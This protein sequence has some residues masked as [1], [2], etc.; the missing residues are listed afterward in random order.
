MLCTFLLNFHIHLKRCL[1]NRLGKKVIVGM[2]KNGTEFETF[3]KAI[4]EEI[5][6]YDG[7]DTVKVE[8]NVKVNGKSGQL[9]QLDV[10]WEFKIAGITHRVAVE[11]KQYAKTISVGKV[12]DFYGALE[13]IGNIHGIFVTTKGYQSGAIKYAAHKGISLK[14]VHEPTSDDIDAHQGIK[15]IHIKGNFM[16]IGNVLMNLSLDI[17]WVLEHT[18]MKEGDQFSF[19]ALNNEIKV[20]DS[21]FNLLGTIHD[22]ENK[23]PREPENT[24]ALTNKYEF[25]DGFIHVPNSKYPLLKLKALHFK[26]DTYSFSTVSEIN[27]KLMAQAVLKDIITG[28][29]HLYKK[30]NNM[31]SA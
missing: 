13:D 9:H 14:V 5:L 24:Q 27:N 21:N 18:N 16:C 7:Y 6:A 4:Y 29:S 28:E 2:A 17:D 30:S 11:C 3:V 1:P 20:I 26:Y 23:L 8:H 31:G 12:R 10:Y 22:F 25:A 19:N 15:T